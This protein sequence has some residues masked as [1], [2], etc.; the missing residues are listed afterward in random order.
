MQ[1]KQVVSIHES[2][3]RDMLRFQDTDITV[4][5]SL[6]LFIVKSSVDKLCGDCS[7]ITSKVRGRSPLA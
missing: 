4:Y 6:F 2:G 7:E 1:W 5:L 3:D